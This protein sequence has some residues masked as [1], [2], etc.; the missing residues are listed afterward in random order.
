MAVPNLHH[1]DGE[2]WS[3]VASVDL[4]CPSPAFW[5]S[6]LDLV[7]AFS[8]CVFPSLPPSLP[9]SARVHGQ[10]CQVGCRP[11]R[12]SVFSL[13]PFSPCAPCSVFWPCPSF[14]VLFL[15]TFSLLCLL[16]RV[17]KPNYFKICASESCEAYL[18]QKVLF[19]FILL[20]KYGTLHENLSLVTYEL[21]SGGA[22]RR[23]ECH[24]G[25]GQGEGVVLE[26]K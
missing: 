8:K 21:L 2:N 18:F 14:H 19:F 13:S 17:L 10:H 12:H 26:A 5:K 23:S 1:F 4:C 22:G 3:S 9:V 7:C 25:G 11:R 20:K 16:E 15:G 6:G 24:A